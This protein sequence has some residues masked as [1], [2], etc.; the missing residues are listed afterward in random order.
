VVLVTVYMVVGCM[1]LSTSTY[2]VLYTCADDDQSG[3]VS[4]CLCYDPGYDVH[5]NYVY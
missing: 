5:R 4:I 3:L 2:T 1:L